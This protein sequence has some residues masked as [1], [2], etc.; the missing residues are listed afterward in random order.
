MD[1]VDAMIAAVEGRPAQPKGRHNRDA[2]TDYDLPALVRGFI[3]INAGN[4]TETLTIREAG[5]MPR[6]YATYQG[7]RVRVTMV[8][9]LGDVGVSRKDDEFGYFAR[10]SIYD[11]TDF[12]QE[13]NPQ[14]P[15][16]RPHAKLHAIRDRM[17][18]WARVQPGAKL[19]EV[20]P[21]DTPVLYTEASKA[22]RDLRKVDPYG[23]QGLS[24]VP[25]LITKVK[26]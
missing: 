23:L 5:L 20:F 24:V 17:G 7:E 21:S 13:R 2:L 9:R 25:V 1:D 3:A 14:A 18:F 15:A 12:S 16:N 22:H 6:L 8:S 4:A 26:D 11:L 10:V 19:A